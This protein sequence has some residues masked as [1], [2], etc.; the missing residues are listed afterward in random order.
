MRTTARY[1]PVVALSRHRRW[2]LDKHFGVNHSPWLVPVLLDPSLVLENEQR[3]AA[4]CGRTFSM[5]RLVAVGS[6]LRCES[7]PAACDS[8]VQ[9]FFVATAPRT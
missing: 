8:G 3:P 2:R 1:F 6:A 4:S 5:S 9:I 7:Q